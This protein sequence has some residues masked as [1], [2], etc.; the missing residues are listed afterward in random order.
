MT[1]SLRFRVPL[2]IAAYDG[3]HAVI[4][5]TPGAQD[6]LTVHLGWETPDGFEIIEVWE[7][8][9]AYDRFV[10]DVWPQITD[11]LGQGPIPA[12]QG[13]EFDLRGLVV[14][15]TELVYV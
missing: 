4:R 9:A 2:P 5:E 15:P 1:Y 10:H 14:T 3:L 6:G 13:E 11:R 8:R 12:P 7:S